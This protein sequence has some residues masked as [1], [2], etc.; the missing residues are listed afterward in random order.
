MTKL[1]ILKRRLIIS[2]IVIFIIIGGLI[3]GWFF[4]EDLAQQKD[5]AVLQARANINVYQARIA[6]SEQ[7]FNIYETSFTAYN[8]L[9]KRIKNGDFVLDLQKAR[10][11]LN[12][13][14]LQHRLNNFSIQMSQQVRYGQEDANTVGVEPVFREVRISFSAL[15]DVHIYAFI[16]NL[17]KMLGYIHFTKINLIRT[18]PLSDDTLREV[19][20]G[21]T[22]SLISA[23]LAFLWMGIAKKSANTEANQNAAP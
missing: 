11:N 18:R 15:S 17:E 19:S 20:R 5:T 7:K 16:K 13:L 22:P 2:G 1:Q 8:E 6:Q 14:R 23:E 4:S 12:A 3:G 21:S 10:K 9:N